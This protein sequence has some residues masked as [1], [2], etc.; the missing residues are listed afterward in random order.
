M[1]NT[2]NIMMRDIGGFGYTSENPIKMPVI[3]ETEPF[4]EVEE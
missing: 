3:P 2:A 1:K 4:L